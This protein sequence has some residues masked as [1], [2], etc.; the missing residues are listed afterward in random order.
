MTGRRVRLIVHGWV[1]V[2]LLLLP[3]FLFPAALAGSVPQE[4]DIKAAFLINFIKFVEWPGPAFDSPGDPYLV[5]V[6]G[7]DPVAAAI[8]GLDNKMVSGRRL[9]VRKRSDLSSLERCHILF[10]GRSE[11]RKVVQILGAV[12]QW[13]VLT[14]ADIDGFARQGGTIG[15]IREDERIRFEINEES[16]SRAGL[17]LNAKLLYLGKIVRGQ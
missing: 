2:I 1:L 7:N 4:A 14:V 8:E 15:F 9:V 3:G 11:N 17:K 13:P 10:V 12:K 5:S 6:V 16:A